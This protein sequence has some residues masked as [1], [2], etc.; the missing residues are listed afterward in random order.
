MLTPRDSAQSAFHEIVS[1]GTAG[2][3]GAD[4]AVINAGRLDSVRRAERS[5]LSAYDSQRTGLLEPSDDVLDDMLR[6]VRKLRQMLEVD[7][8]SHELRGGPSEDAW[9]AP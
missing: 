7:V 8:G 5:I 1:M 9:S 3:M 4:M 6:Q 2:V